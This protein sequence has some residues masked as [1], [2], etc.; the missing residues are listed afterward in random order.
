MKVYATDYDNTLNYGGITSELTDAINSWRNSGNLFGI[1]TGRPLCSILA[2]MADDKIVY[3]FILANNGAVHADRNGKVI[4][5]EPLSPDDACELLKYLVRLNRSSVRVDTPET[6]FCLSDAGVTAE[7]DI[8]YD[9]DII[10]AGDAKVRNITEIAA[11]FSSGEVSRKSEDFMDYVSERFEG[12]IKPLIPGIPFVDYIRRDV[13][14]NIGLKSFIRRFGIDPEIIYTT[15]DS[16]ND[17][18]MLTDRDFA[19]YASPNA[20]EE[21]KK[22]TGR[23]AAPIQILNGEI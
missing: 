14:K 21:V 7:N 20:T 9:G 5:I 8:R 2:Q 11:M 23:I 10:I 19:G 1:V 17:L 4:E 3:D 6:S 16:Q 12:R 18:S 15:G 22:A 13:G